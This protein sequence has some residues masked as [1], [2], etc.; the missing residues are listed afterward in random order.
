MSFFDFFRN[1]SLFDKGY[2]DAQDFYDYYQ[3]LD[4]V[5]NHIIAF[6]KLDN[7]KPQSEKNGWY[8][9]VWEMEQIPTNMEP[10]KAIPLL[11]FVSVPILPS[12][13]PN[14]CIANTPMTGY[15]L[16]E[17]MYETAIKQGMS[18]IEAYHELDSKMTRQALG[19]NCN[20]SLQYA[21]YMNELYNK[22]IEPI[23]K[24]A[25]KLEALLKVEAK[26]YKECEGV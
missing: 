22:V 11:E 8:A 25:K 19:L 7:A 23:E 16:A 1:E 12:S 6:Q 2:N 18:S 10:N 5:K 17:T 21:I 9:F 13:L 15:V 20:E 26:G 3:T 24:Q 14:A 4:A